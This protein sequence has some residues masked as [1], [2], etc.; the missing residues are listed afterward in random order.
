MASFQLYLF[1]WLLSLHPIVT[2]PN[3]YPGNKWC[4]VFIN[5][6]SILIIIII[7][8]II[9]HTQPLYGTFSG[10]PGW[11]SATRK[12]LLDFMVQGEISEADTSTIRLGA[13]PVG[14]ISNLPPSYPHF[15][16]RCLSSCKPPNLS[17]LGR[18]APN[19]L[20]CLPSGLVNNNSY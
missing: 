20:A 7:I 1:G 10:L 11:A 6:M 15:Y 16:A 9:T 12:L 17:W 2:K 8:I 19:M 3:V 14:L 13:T 4:R 5:W 18:Q